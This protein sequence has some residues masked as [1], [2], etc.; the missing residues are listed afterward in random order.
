[1]SETKDLDRVVDEIQDQIRKKDEEKY[2]KTVLREFYDPSNLGRIEEPDTLASITGSCGDTMEFSLRIRNERIVEIG[3][4]TDGCGSSIAC[5]SMLTRIVKGRTVKEA[6][7]IG[8]ADI[9]EALGGLPE[10]NEHCARLSA[11]TLHKA[12]ANYLDT[13]I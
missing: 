5:G 9:L 8:E 10:E 13:S 11:D 6:M 4:M 3:F 12:I 7:E 1:M 2:S